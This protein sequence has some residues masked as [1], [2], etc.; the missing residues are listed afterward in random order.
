MGRMQSE[1]SWC[2]CCSSCDVTAR[3]TESIASDAV[4]TVVWDARFGVMSERVRPFVRR[5]IHTAQMYADALE[6]MD[7]K[8]NQKKESVNQDH[9][10]KDQD[11]DVK[12]NDLKRKSQD[13]DE[14]RIN[15]QVRAAC[16]EGPRA[17]G[18]E[19]KWT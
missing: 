1:W 7:D 4:L 16:F 17:L 5:N 19:V 18:F 12:R 11:H 6:K 10:V 8:E 2:E 14:R 9:D 15:S 13:K 3:H